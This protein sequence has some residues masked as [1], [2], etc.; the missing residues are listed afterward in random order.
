MSAAFIYCI[1]LLLCLLQ[2]PP[3]AALTWRE[4]KLLIKATDDK[5]AGYQLAGMVQFDALAQPAFLHRT[6]NKF[7]W[8]GQ[9]WQLELLTGPL[10]LRCVSSVVCTQWCCCTASCR[11][12]GIVDVAGRCASYTMLQATALI[13]ALFSCVLSLFT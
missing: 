2:V 10:P 8:G 5:Q 13:V 4:G 7:S 1:T 3:G 6:M 9:A 11:V 12:T